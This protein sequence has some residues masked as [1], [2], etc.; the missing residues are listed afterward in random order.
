MIQEIV[1]AALKPFTE[2]IGWQAFAYGVT[3]KVVLIYGKSFISQFSNAANEADDEA[4]E[5][6]EEQTS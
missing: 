2:T 5:E 4:S 6:I 1:G 3:G